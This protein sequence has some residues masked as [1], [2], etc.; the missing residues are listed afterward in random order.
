M[1]FPPVSPTGM[2]SPTMNM[3]MMQN[4]ND[5]FM[6]NMMKMCADWSAFSSAQS[7]LRNMEKIGTYQYLKQQLAAG[8]DPKVW[9]EDKKSIAAV[10]KAKRGYRRVEN[11]DANGHKTYSVTYEPVAK[12]DRK[13]K[14]SKIIK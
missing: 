3:P 12:N 7:L 9:V 14:L 8:F 6:Q 2:H 4:H 5:M 1:G 13:I 11:V 10:K